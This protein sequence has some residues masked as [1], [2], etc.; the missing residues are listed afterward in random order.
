MAAG[1][2]VFVNDWDVMK[3]ITAD[4][5][6]A[7]LYKTKDENDLFRQFKFYLHDPMS[8]KQRA[9]ENA[10][11]ARETYSIQNHCDRLSE[12]YQKVLS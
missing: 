2:P 3:E 1:I 6:R 7:I 4:G 12:V 5:E 10:V 8:Y 11:W 9:L